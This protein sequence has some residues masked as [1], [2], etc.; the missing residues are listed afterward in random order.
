MHRSSKAQGREPRPGDLWQGPSPKCSTEQLQQATAN[1]LGWK[2]SQSSRHHKGAFW[3]KQG[4]DRP[5]SNTPAALILGRIHPD[6]R[7]TTAVSWKPEEPQQPSSTR[8]SRHKK[9]CSIPIRSTTSPTRFI[10]HQ[11]AIL[12]ACRQ[13]DHNP[14]SCWTVLCCRQQLCARN[15]SRR[16]R[17]C[18]GSYRW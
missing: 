16:H 17:E 1:A 18:H 10:Q 5:S 13:R 12:C 3:Y 4:I 9:R 8:R 6:A 14:W 11:V 15:Y 7:Q 2:S